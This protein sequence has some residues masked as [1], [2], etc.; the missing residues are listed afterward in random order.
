MTAVTYAQRVSRQNEDMPTTI[1]KTV[2]EIAAENPRSVRVFEKYGIDYCCG[3][4]LALSDA[5]R[6]RGLAPDQ[7]ARELEA[8]S[9]PSPELAADW[10]N[11]SLNQLI[12]HILTRHHG[13]LK[14]ELPRLSAMVR[15]V[16]A[17]HAERHGDSLEPLAR[18]FAGLQAEL[19]AHLMKEEMVLFP[20]M[21]NMELA[22]ES[23][24]PAPA[25]HCGS[26]NNPIRV[27]EHEHDSAG[28]ALAFLRQVSDGYTPP[29]DAC[30]TYRAMLHGLAD[31]EA[32]LHQHIHLENN[33]LFPRAAA[34]E[35]GL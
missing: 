32:D 30:N 17:V 2:G 21:R 6:R 16:A 34:L 29:P 23:G 31:L 14:T 7:V 11:A 10:Q 35:G 22:A 27:M 18:T 12:D 33:I 15:K 1:E 28:E 9:V 26:V 5:C 24:R 8:G 19:E 25:A 4:K 13:Y 3:G 20:I